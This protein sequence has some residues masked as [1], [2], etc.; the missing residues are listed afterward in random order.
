MKRLN[1]ISFAVIALLLVLLGMLIES[2][3]AAR[4]TVTTGGTP[5]IMVIIRTDTRAGTVE[6]WLLGLQDPPPWAKHGE[7]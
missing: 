7:R 1:Y 5:S 6:T 4:Y 3:T 2:R